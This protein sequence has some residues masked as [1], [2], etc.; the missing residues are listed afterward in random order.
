MT[1]NLERAN[2]TEIEEARS[3]ADYLGWDEQKHFEGKRQ[4]EE[5]IILKLL[6][7]NIPISM[8]TIFRNIN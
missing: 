7:D 1:E 8:D 2:L 6:A 4:D 3:F 5:L